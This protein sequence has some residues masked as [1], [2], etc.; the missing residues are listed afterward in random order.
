MDLLVDKVVVEVVDA[1]WVAVVGYV[2]VDALVDSVV[3]E[4][5]DKVVDVVGV[6]VVWYGFLSTN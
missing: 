4:V 3:D 2:N 6:A 1:V 5:V